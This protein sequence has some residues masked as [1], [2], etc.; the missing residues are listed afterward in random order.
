MKKVSQY[1][2]KELIEACSK[3]DGQ[4]QRELYDRYSPIM[5]PVCIRYVG[6]EVAKDVLQDGF[7]TIFDK[8][9]TFKGEGSFEGWIRRIFINTA[10]MELRKNDALK[11]SE[12]IDSVPVYEMGMQ[13]YGAVEQ[14]SM[15]ELLALVGEMPAGF[16]SVFNLFVFEGYSHA[17]IA[18]ALGINEVSSRS[19][20]SRARAWLRERVEKLYDDR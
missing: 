11:N 20:L 15:K 12:E 5:Y 7:I 17:D 8:I 13:D 19:Q 14:M 6:R 1:T 16:R 3:R 4:A 10:L 18:E 9:D 2:E